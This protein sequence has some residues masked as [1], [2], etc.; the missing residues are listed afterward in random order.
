VLR[1]AATDE[2]DAFLPL[3]EVVRKLECIVIHI[4]RVRRSE[5]T[6]D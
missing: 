3:D 4:I 5:G 6:T 2:I 1:A